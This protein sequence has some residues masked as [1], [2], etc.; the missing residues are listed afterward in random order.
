MEQ[1]EGFRLSPQQERLW[2]LQGG[3]DEGTPYRAQCVLRVEGEVKRDAL[4]AALRAAFE[5]HEILR[6]NFQRLHGLAVAVQ[7]ISEACAPEPREYDLTGLTAPEQKDKLDELTRE[8]RR[9]PLHFE[10]G[11]LPNVALLKLAPE[12]HALVI[13]LPSMCT[14]AE[15][16]RN[17]ARE[18]SLHYSAASGAGEAAP[19]P[20]QYA[21]YA[22]WQ[23]ELLESEETRA[24][25]DYWRRKEVRG[26]SSLGLP[27]ERGGAVKA[28]FE[29]R[30]FAVELPAELLSEMEE[31]ALKFKGTASDFLLACWHVLLWRLTGQ[32]PSVVG[33]AFDG[34]KYEEFRDALGIFSRYLPTTCRLEGETAFGEVLSQV[35]DETRGA[36]KWQEYF[37]WEQVEAPDGAEGES[38]F[39]PFVFEFENAR[40]FECAASGATFS[41]AEQHTLFDRFKVNLSCAR[42]DEGL[43][44]E[45]H[46]DAGLLTEDDIRRVAASYV[47]LLGEALRNFESPVAGLKILDDAERRKLLSGVNRTAQDYGDD[48][49]L[50]ELFERQAARTPHTT[51]IVSEEDSL[52]YAELDERA[53]RLAQRLRARGIRPGHFVGVCLERSAEM[54]V[55]LLAVLK[56][57]AAY[58]PLDPNYPAGRLAFML[59]DT[60]VPVI[61]T[62]QN[63]A[64]ELPQSSA[65]VLRLDEQGGEEAEAFGGGGPE[66]GGEASR[67][68]P[69]YPAY[70]IY[71]SGSTGRPK[72][73]VVSHRSINN[74]LLWMQK[75][76]PLRPDDRLLQKTVF[77]FDASIWE[78]FVPLLAGAQLVMA[79]PGG[80]QDS[81]YLVRAVIE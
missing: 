58:V 64:G 12:S 50:H 68:S 22:A 4:L 9:L 36:H 17:L 27:F 49:C 59:E 19:D 1:V 66:P 54:V 28:N 60:R 61:I 80:H 6:T 69:D 44:L 46:Y 52:T 76:F 18:V 71:T 63:L 2:W 75:T 30:S 38:A 81:S 70:V 48:V 11:L 25:R 35:G 26:L 51:A 3:S 65:Q 53:S 29:T 15:G 5:R 42:R 74:R 43:L 34:R 32:S 41:L 37:N 40:P 79:R 56:A 10:H 7:V 45:F 8:A 57:G 20:M 39:F 72:G 62:R 67:V 23:H 77:S 33:A 78:I 47:T 21:D 13:T 55:S 24:G 73:V 16:L 14:D 31:A